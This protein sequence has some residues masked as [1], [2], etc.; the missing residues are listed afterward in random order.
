MELTFLGTS[1]MVPTKERNVQ[2]MFLSYKAQGILIDC[3]EGTQRQMNLAGINRNKVNT[4]L[5]THWHGD[6]VGGIIGLLQTISSKENPP[7]IEIYGPV[8]TKKRVQHLLDS[9]IFEEKNLNLKIFE[10]NPKKVDVFKETADYTLLCAHMNHTTPC[11]AYSFVEKDVRKINVA[12]S[13]A[14]GIS[15]SPILGK[16]QDGKSVVFNGKKITPDDV[17][18][19]KKGRKI[20][21]VFDTIPN[22]KAHLIAKDSDLLVSEA[23]YLPEMKDNA[24]K[25]KHLTTQDAALI[26]TNANVKRL[27]ITHFSQRYKLVDVLESGVKTYFSNSSCAHDFM[28]IKF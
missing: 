23:V 12:K 28:K 1:C 27:I 13:K 7:Q 3:G 18:F 9:V 26:A 25:Y 2:G 16:L 17:S 11:L 20:T 5:V 8:G 21:F 14:L 6:H 15:Q 22:E 4:I 10:L 24:E 19:V